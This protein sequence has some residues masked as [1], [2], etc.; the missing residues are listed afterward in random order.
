MTS[1]TDFLAEGIKTNNITKNSVKPTHPDTFSKPFRKLETAREVYNKLRDMVLVKAKPFMKDF[2]IVEPHGKYSHFY[3]FHKESVNA[4]LWKMHN[5]MLDGD[6]RHEAPDLFF[7]EVMD[8]CLRD[9][10]VTAASLS[11]D[12]INVKGFG[13][14]YAVATAAVSKEYQ[15]M[16]LMY[17]FYKY[18]ITSGFGLLSDDSQ[19]EG[20]VKNWNKLATTPGI[21]VAGLTVGNKIIPLTMTKDGLAYMKLVHEDGKDS[22]DIQGMLAY[23]AK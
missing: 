7:G 1:F 18:I 23:K 4:A 10:K 17:E 8:K 9:P 16:G 12:L 22:G 21:T 11:A 2:L 3:I 15:G 14:A 5:S 6:D 13:K 20:A 19:S